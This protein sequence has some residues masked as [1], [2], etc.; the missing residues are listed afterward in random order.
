MLHCTATILLAA[1][2]GAGV[3]EEAEEGAGG[4]EEDCPCGHGGA[5]SREPPCAPRSALLP[6]ARVK[7]VRPRGGNF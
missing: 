3:P 1:L 2:V 6:P 7:V 4:P 5:L